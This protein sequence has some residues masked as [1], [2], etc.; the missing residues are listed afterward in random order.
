[1]TDPDVTLT[2]YGLALL[3]A[4]LVWRLWRGRR[5]GLP[6][7]WLRLFFGGV[8]AAAALGGTVH[9][10]FA[11]E[12][13]T[14]HEVLWSATLISIGVAALAAW[15]LGARLVLRDGL[16]RGLIGLA[17]LVF[18]AYVALV[19]AGYREFRIAILHYVPATVFLLLAVLLANRRRPGSGLRLAAA[20]LA[21][22]FVAALLQQLGIG[23][24][25]VWLDHNALYHAFEAGA[26]VL[27]YVGL[28][29]ALGRPL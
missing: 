2:D 24:H 15:G 3:C 27:L 29:R 17:G 10:F 8:G 25:P 1:M 18:L 23:I 5:L 12:G 7:R 21:L 6:G 4:V 11:A 9:G 20:G 14:A 26:L 16:A 22:S 28:T 19:L 13:T